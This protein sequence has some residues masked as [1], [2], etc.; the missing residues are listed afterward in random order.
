M[1]GPIAVPK[2]AMAVHGSVSQVR[3]LVLNIS[4]TLP[5]MTELGTADR[6]PVTRRPT[7]PE[8]GEGTEAINA[9]KPLYR[10]VVMIYSH[11]R[12]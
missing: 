8:A 7:A 1:I 4:S 2:V 12:P 6:N 3:C 11:L 9:Q 5:L 10:A